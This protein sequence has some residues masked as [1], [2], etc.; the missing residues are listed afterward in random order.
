MKS[1][2]PAIPAL[3]YSV[4]GKIFVIGEYAVLG[5]F[6]AWVAA[7]EPRFQFRISDAS[8]AFHPESPAGLFAPKLRGEFRDPWQGQGG[9]G[10]STAEFAF[11]ARISGIVD[12]HEA[13]SEYRKLFTA[14]PAPGKSLPSGA[15]LLAQWEGGV[16]EWN[17]TTGKLRDLSKSFEDVPLLVFSA[18]HLPSRKT[19]THEHLKALSLEP[20]RF[21]HLLPILEL[22]ESARVAGDD[23]LLG[24]ALSGYAEALAE[25]GWE[26]EAAG[27]DRMAFAE[28][29][30][31]L[32]VKGCGAMQS[33][34]MIILVESIS[35]E[36]EN[37]QAVIN[38]AEERGLRLLSR[39]IPRV[40]GLRVEEEKT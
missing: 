39:G 14:G 11:A 10:G 7:I 33:D 4:P 16:I 35:A 6:P 34:A 24:Q 40:D 19:K 37:T 3:Q 12:A 15:D 2:A 28:M 13:H 25:Q 23:R 36:D 22:A 17:P 30:G 32:G 21:A 27:G 1:Q 8:A 18:S 9:F 20:P 26:S 38:F 5:G 31:V 29:P